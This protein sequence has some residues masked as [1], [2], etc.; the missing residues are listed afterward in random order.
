[1]IS[2]LIGLNLWFIDNLFNHVADMTVKYQ[3]FRWLFFF[4]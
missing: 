2:L 4:R 3:I 1:M